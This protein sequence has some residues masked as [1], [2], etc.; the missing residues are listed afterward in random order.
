[1]RV[2]IQDGH[3]SC[4]NHAQPVFTRV[5]QQRHASRFVMRVKQLDGAWSLLV[6]LKTMHGLL[7]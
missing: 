7:L 5:E 4:R 2:E 3:L 6:L 1:M